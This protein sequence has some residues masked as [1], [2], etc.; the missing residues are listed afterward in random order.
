MKKNLLITT[1]IASLLFIASCGGDDEPTISPIVGKWI[2]DDIEATDLPA[3]YAFAINPEGSST[4]WF[5]DEYVIEFFE[6]G[7]YERE[8]SNTSAGDLEDTGEWELDGDDLDLDI[9][10]F[11]TQDVVTSF[12]VDG[13]ITDR[14]MT[15][16]GTDGWFAWPASIV[17]NPDNPLDTAA[18]SGTLNELFAE[19]GEIVDVTVT[20]EFD[21]D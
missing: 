19:Y 12:T 21:R 20:M 9:D 16:I 1:L 10:E 18:A 11:D 3:G 5:E 6:D 13:E 17:D 14:S 15:L 2:L 4:S 8:L 7:T